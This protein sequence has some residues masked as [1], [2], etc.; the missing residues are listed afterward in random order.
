MPAKFLSE[1]MIE[2]VQNTVADISIKLIRPNGLALDL[3]GN[4]AIRL[5]IFQQ[6]PIQQQVAL[7]AGSAVGALTDGLVKFSLT[8]VDNNFVGFA[9]GHVIVT[10]PS[11]NIGF[12]QIEFKYSKNP[13]P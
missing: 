10:K 12:E 13:L 3:T 6:T 2:L 1:N 9:V 7:K 4:T 11:G 8:Q 5:G